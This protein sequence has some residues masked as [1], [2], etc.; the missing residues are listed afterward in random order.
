MMPVSVYGA[1]FAPVVL[2]LAIIAM[3][4][5]HYE[6]V[7]RVRRRDRRRPSIYRCAACGCVYEDSRNV[8]LSA[9]GHCGMLNESVRR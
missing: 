7:R 6:R 2:C 9:C 8:P 4:W 1:F 3:L 5:F